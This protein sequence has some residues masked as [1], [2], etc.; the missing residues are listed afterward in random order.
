MKATNGSIGNMQASDELLLDKFNKLTDA[1]EDMTEQ[2]ALQ[3]KQIREL[4]GILHQLVK[5]EFLQKLPGRRLQSEQEPS[6]EQSNT[7]RCPTSNDA[8]DSHDAEQHDPDSDEDVD[9]DK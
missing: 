5:P 1:V 2:I 4:T 3:Q 9:H 6:S 8:S 7:I